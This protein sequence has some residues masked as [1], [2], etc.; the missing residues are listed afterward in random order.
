MGLASPP[1]HVPYA[2]PL[3]SKGDSIID[4]ILIHTSL[5]SEIFNPDDAESKSFQLSSLTN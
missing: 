1:D 5:P 4:A 2:R 3:Y